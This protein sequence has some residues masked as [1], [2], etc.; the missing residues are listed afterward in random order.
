[1]LLGGKGHTNAVMQVERGSDGHD[2]TDCTLGRDRSRIPHP[3]IR[4]KGPAKTIVRGAGTMEL[5][6]MGNICRLATADARG[7]SI[8]VVVEE[9]WI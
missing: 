1:M 7:R 6:A 8:A 9:A 2:V 4:H 5:S 3:Q